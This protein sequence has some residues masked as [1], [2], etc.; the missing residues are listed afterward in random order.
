MTLVVFGI[1]KSSLILKYIGGNNERNINSKKVEWF[2]KYYIS[3]LFGF[4]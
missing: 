4:K 1:L 3:T 2:I